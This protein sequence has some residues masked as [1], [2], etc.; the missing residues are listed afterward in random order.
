M[1]FGIRGRTEPI[2]Y[3]VGRW[4]LIE[5]AADGQDAFDNDGDPSPFERGVFWRPTNCVEATA[6]DPDFCDAQGALAPDTPPVQEAVIGVDAISFTVN[7]GCTLAG[8]RREI[9]DDYRATA[10]QQLELATGKA[11]EGEFW[12]GA[13]GVTMQTLD[14]A[15]TEVTGDP[16]G[17]APNIAATVVGGGVVERQLGL[18]LLVKGLS[19]CG[20]GA[21][22]MIHAPA[23]IVQLWQGDG[24]VRYEDDG[25]PVTIRGDRI[26]VGSGYPG[27]APAG[28]A[29]PTGNQAWVFATGPV[30]LYLDELTDAN[31]EATVVES[32]D[33]R[34]NL[35]Q[36]VARREALV[37]MD[38]C[39]KYAVLLDAA[40]GGGG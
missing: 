30:E 29:A 16:V 27:T 35:A 26:V 9:T 10:L 33:R 25:R 22:G 34:I 1:S 37:R 15:A 6:W 19:D 36:F 4:G 7:Y 23:W 14:S 38:N 11:L 32:I 3:Q 17:N 8:G 21:V 40:Q 28:E 12:T 5:Q 18:G 31:V 13:T 24:L 39:C 2:E 20:N